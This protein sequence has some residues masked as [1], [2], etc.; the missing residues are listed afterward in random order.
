[1]LT[2]NIFTHCEF[3]KIQIADKH[4]KTLVKHFAMLL[5]YP[6]CFLTLYRKIVTL[7]L[8]LFF[9]LLTSEQTS[10]SFSTKLNSA[11]TYFFT[12]LMN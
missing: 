4:C 1:M 9:R 3:A 11:S 12:N 10:Q 5:H 2:S 7:T 8:M 6:V